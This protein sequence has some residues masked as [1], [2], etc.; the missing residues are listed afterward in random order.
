MYKLPSLR[1]TSFDLF[2]VIYIHTNMYSD[3]ERKKKLSVHLGI[4]QRI[5][6]PPNRDFRYP[7][8]N[9]I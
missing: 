7:N 4:N 5:S 6:K 8:S 1:H 3:L 9:L 2:E